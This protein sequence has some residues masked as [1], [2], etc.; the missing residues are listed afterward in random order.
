MF[1][2]VFVILILLFFL[3][4]CYDREEIDNITYV[5]ALGIDKGEKDNLKLT[6]QYFT[7]NEKSADDVGNEE[8]A[9]IVIE[10]SSIMNAINIVNNSI[11]RKVS[12]SHTKL[13]VLSEELARQGN[14]IR[15]LKPIQNSREF[16]PNIYMAVSKDSA[17]DY[18]KTIEKLNKSNIARYYRLIF[19]SYEYSG[20]Y[21]ASTKD[22]FYYKMCE[23]DVGAVVPYVSI[24]HVKDVENIAK[25]VSKN[26]NYKAGKIPEKGKEAKAQIMGVAVFNE[27]KMVGVLNGE[28]VTYFLMA[29]G[30]FK[31]SLYTINDPLSP[32]DIVNVRL[33]KRARPKIKVSIRNNKPKIDVDIKLVAEYV[34]FESDVD[35][36]KSRNNARLVNH[37]ENTIKGN[38]SKVLEKT[39]K[40]YKS[41]ICLFGK[42]ARKNFLTWKEWEKYGWENKYKDVN[43]DVNV[44]VK[45]KMLGM[46]KQ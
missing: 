17:S 6:M 38:I 28:E 14:I 41:D 3:T 37:I 30:E 18:L 9:S 33:N 42:H 40:E 29:I 34:Y 35:Y 24:N 43:F 21:M 1:K 13:I 39:A 16:R 46:I 22:D 23:C 10:A 45:I 12:F 2:K 36:N 19:S 4:G 31:K 27:D 44:S 15:L 20:Y 7:I 5:I 25:Q 11:D 32:K 8:T 26:G